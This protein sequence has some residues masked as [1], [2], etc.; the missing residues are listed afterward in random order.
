M[1]YLFYNYYSCNTCFQ[2]PGNYLQIFRCPVLTKAFV[3]K[4]VITGPD[5]Q[6]YTQKFK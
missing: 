2:K 4:G 1:I 3:P 5:G 6:K